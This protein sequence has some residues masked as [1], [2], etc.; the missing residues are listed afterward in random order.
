[1]GDRHLRQTDTFI[2]KDHQMHQPSYP[3]GLGYCREICNCN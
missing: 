2:A 3:L 1:M